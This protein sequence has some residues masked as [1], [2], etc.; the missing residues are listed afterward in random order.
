MEDDTALRTAF[1]K[2]LTQLG[3]RVIEASNGAEAFELWRNHRD[4]IN[5]LLTDLV[6]PGGMNGKEFAEKLLKE[7]PKL[8]IIYMSGYSPDITLSDLRIGQGIHFLAKPFDTI[9]LAKT[10]RT[11]LE[12]A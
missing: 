2:A 12:G 10:V 9:A 6:M 11:V 1:K 5:L 8:K 7:T 4:H 3:Y